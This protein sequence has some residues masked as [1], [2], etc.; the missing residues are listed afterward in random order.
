MSL[1]RKSSIVILNG[2]GNSHVRF[3]TEEESLVEEEKPLSSPTLLPSKIAM[4]STDESTTGKLLSL[5]LLPWLI[6]R[7]LL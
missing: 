6:E 4:L 3:D 5:S 2:G 7:N 1:K